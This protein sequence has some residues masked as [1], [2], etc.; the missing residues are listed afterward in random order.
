[1]C[2]MMSTA[3]DVATRMLVEKKGALKQVRAYIIQFAFSTGGTDF[4]GRTTMEM[5]MNNPEFYKDTVDPFN[6][7]GMRGDKARD[8]DEDCSVPTPDPNF[9]KIWGGAVS[10]ASVDAR[11]VRRSCMLFEEGRGDKALQYGQ[12]MNI[13]VREPFP[14]KGGAQSSIAMFGRLPSADIAKLALEGMNK[15][16]AEGKSAKVGQGPSPE[17]RQKCYVKYYIVA[18][19]EDGTYA[20]CKYD[21]GEPYEVT[22]MSS[23]TACLVLA[24]SLDAVKPKDCGG[25][26]TPSYAFAG[27]NF[28]ELLMNNRWACNEKHAKM[29]WEVVEGKPEQDEILKLVQ[30]RTKTYMVE[31]AEGKLQTMALP[32]Y[33]K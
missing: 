29:H 24:E 11:C 16:L 7:G 31:M 27:T 3:T 5:L 21:G 10:C 17:T 2:G 14:A 25:F 13:M 12:E 15:G 6:L 30:E 28:A 9:P 18:E 19:A 20:Y 26:L 1:M 22:A 8:I 4:A 23:A 32:D 33:K